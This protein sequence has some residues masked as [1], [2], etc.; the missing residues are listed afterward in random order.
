LA[1]LLSEHSGNRI[2]PHKNCKNHSY[3][4]NQDRKL[5]NDMKE[6]GFCPAY[7]IIVS[8]KM[9]K[10]K[11]KFTILSGHRRCACGIASGSG[12]YVMFD[13]NTSHTPQYYAKKDEMGIKWSNKSW[14]NFYSGFKTS[15]ADLLDFCK[16]YEISGSI[17]PAI[18]ILQQKSFGLNP[19][20]K[21]DFANG[22]FVIKNKA[23]GEKCAKILI[24][25]GNYTSNPFKQKL[26]ASLT[27]VLTKQDY[28]HKRMMKNL[29]KC[30][31]SFKERASSV[32]DHVILLEKIYNYGL[33]K[34]DKKCVRW[35]NDYDATLKTRKKETVNLRES[36][37]KQKKA[38][39]QKIRQIN[40]IAQIKSEIMEKA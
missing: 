29:K 13:Y 36:I 25:Y 18:M 31:E 38:E 12:A 37:K 21:R 23:F 2:L 4:G 26:V 16:K 14:A 7:P 17:S 19:D 3:S 24:D 28:S 15:Y 34:G 10:G 27:W 33:K 8:V 39:R 9:R 35:S 20:T 32:E 6:D 22:K 40:K 1:E 11:A 5:A 30:P